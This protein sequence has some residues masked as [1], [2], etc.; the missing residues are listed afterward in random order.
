[1]G[2]SLFQE[3]ELKVRPS[4][5]HLVT[6]NRQWHRI[7][8]GF[9]TLLPVRPV[10]CSRLWKVE[11]PLYPSVLVVLL[12]V[13]MSPLHGC[14]AVSWGFDWCDLHAVHHAEVPAVVRGIRDVPHIRS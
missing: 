5:F 1:M 4:L 9:G 3:G 2:P 14:P 13:V 7:E 11:L 10:A 8:M 12:A 6:H